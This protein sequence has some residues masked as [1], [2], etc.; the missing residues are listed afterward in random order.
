MS[1][2]E[3][4]LGKVEQKTGTN[5]TV[6]VLVVICGG[7]A[8]LIAVNLFLYFYARHTHGAKPGKKLSK[9]KEQRK[10]MTSPV[11]N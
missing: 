5:P 3:E 9:K 8:V 11:S 6:V 7:V 10:R 4:V 2:T 1:S